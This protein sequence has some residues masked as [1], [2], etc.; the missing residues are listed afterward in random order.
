MTIIGYMTDI[1]SILKM[2]SNLK[3]RKLLAEATVSLSY[4]MV[5]ANSKQVYCLG[6]M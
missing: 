1:V 4:G 2:A 6:N 5:I 3:Q